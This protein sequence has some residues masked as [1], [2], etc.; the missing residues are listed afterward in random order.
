MTQLPSRQFRIARRRERTTLI[1]CDRRSAHSVVSGHLPW[2]AS[3][4]SG[5][6]AAQEGPKHLQ[7]EVGYITSF[8]HD[9]Q[10][11]AQTSN[12]RV[13]AHVRLRP[14][15]GLRE[16]SPECSVGAAKSAAKRFANPCFWRSPPLDQTASDQHIRILQQPA[17]HGGPSPQVLGS[18]PRARS[19]END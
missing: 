2:K 9:V 12:D 11:G 16:A 6:L 7:V 3:H 14:F 5:N 18:N 8:P 15:G 19:V 10:H 13:R 4:T 17:K 1:H